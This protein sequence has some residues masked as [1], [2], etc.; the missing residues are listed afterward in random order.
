[1]FVI[2]WHDKSNSNFVTLLIDLGNKF[3][4]SFSQLDEVL[5][6]PGA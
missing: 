2:N 4:H 3:V 1:M 5:L 6:I